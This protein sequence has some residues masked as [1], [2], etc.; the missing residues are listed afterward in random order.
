MVADDVTTRHLRRGRFR[1]LQNHVKTRQSRHGPELMIPGVA[2]GS[3]RVLTATAVQWLVTG[4]GGIV[5]AEPIR[6]L[7]TNHQNSLALEGLWQH[8]LCGPAVLAN[9]A[10]ACGD[11]QGNRVQVP[12]GARRC[13]RGAARREGESR[14]LGRAR[15]SALGRLRRC[16]VGENLLL[17]MR[18][19]EDLQGACR[20]RQ[21]IAVCG[22]SRK[23]RAAAGGTP[24]RPICVWM[25]G[26]K[27][28]EM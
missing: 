9:S 7:Y 23:M 20:Q 10:S 8:A 17:Q 12:G 1:E 4:F 26:P 28:A 22:R 16:G 27:R 3:D 11:G 18:K 21:T 25:I 15:A 14:S 5:R 19:P 24:S 13:E 2:A 6:G